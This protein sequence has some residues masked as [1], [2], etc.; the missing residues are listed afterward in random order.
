[1]K[2]RG[3]AYRIAPVAVAACL[4][5]LMLIMFACTGGCKGSAGGGG[6][7]SAQ[8]NISQLS[9]TNSA[10]SDASGDYTAL[11]N[12]VQGIIGPYKGNV[13]VAFISLASDEGSFSIAGTKAVP[14]ASMLK[15]PILACL[16]NETATG[17]LTLND[18][19]VIKSSEVVGGSGVGLEAGQTLSVEQLAT[20]MIAESDNTAANAI[21]DLLGKNEINVFFES[22]GLRQTVLN[23]LFMTGNAQGDN[24]TSADDVALVFER[25][26][27]NE[28]A[29][30]RLCELAREMLLHQSDDEAMAQGLPA[31]MNAG[32]KTGSL[33]LV[34][35]D[36]GILFNKA[37]TP[38]CVLVVLT[39]GMSDQ[40]ANRLIAT[41]TRVVCK[42]LQ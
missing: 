20:L 30:S 15:V 5:L 19:Y 10:A 27:K 22:Q 39:Q 18:S 4:C 14:S 2:D 35:H 13:S 6:R 9:S 3:S 36:G 38:K 8:Q 23:H 21:I 41:I 12:E 16:L 42:N 34:R 29:T 25:I 24:L 31:T 33:T 7:V 32:H 1:M 28:I 17:S 11:S 26:A 40:S 37:G